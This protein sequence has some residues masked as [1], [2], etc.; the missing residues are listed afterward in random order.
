MTHTLCKIKHSFNKIYLQ[1][2]T[3]T[4]LAELVNQILQGVAHTSVGKI[5]FTQ[6]ERN[7]YV[8]YLSFFYNRKLHYFLNHPDIFPAIIVRSMESIPTIK[9][10]VKKVLEDNP[11]CA[12][13]KEAVLSLLDSDVVFGNKT[14]NQKICEDL[15][16]CKHS[17]DYICH[18]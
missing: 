5:Y 17:L 9:S 7:W 16:S 3:C 12:D 15:K 6:Q 10:C 18:Y 8:H 1:S 13:A 14:V 4:H 2:V 11:A